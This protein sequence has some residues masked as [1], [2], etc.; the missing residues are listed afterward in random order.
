MPTLTSDVVSS[1]STPSQYF[2]IKRVGYENID[3]F[4]ES[5][6]SNYLKYKFLEKYTSIIEPYVD[7][8]LKM[9]DLYKSSKNTFQ[10]E[11]CPK[12]KN[13]GIIME[14]NCQVGS[15]AYNF[16]TSKPFSSHINFGC[17]PFDT[18]S[19]TVKE[20]SYLDGST[21]LSTFKGN[22]I[23]TYIRRELRAL[24]SA[25]LNT[26][27]QTMYKIWST[28]ETEGAALYG[29]KFHSITYLLRFHHF[30]AADRKT[31]HIHN[32]NGILMQHT[33][34]ENIFEA[35]LQ[36]IDPSIALP[37]WDF[38][39]D[40]A[41]GKLANESY[42][43]TP[44]IFGHMHKPR[45]FEGGFTYSQDSIADGVIP[46]GLWK[47]FKSD[48]NVFP[49][50]DYGYGYMRGP[51]NL[52]PNPYISRYTFNFSMYKMP[53]CNDHYA[54]MTDESMMSFFNFGEFAPHGNVH[55]LTGG[56]YGCD[57]FR[58]MLD[59][60]YILD[61]FSLQK[62][63]VSWSAVIMKTAYRFHMVTPEKNCKVN[64]DDVNLS[65]CKYQCEESS[66]EDLFKFISSLASSKDDPG[67][68]N[69]DLVKDGAKEAWMEFI[70]GGNGGKVH[71]QQ[72]T[73]HAVHTYIHAYTQ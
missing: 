73:I 25:D 36:A 32:G 13:G 66:K 28:S 54:L 43:L 41:E 62:M 72:F 50:M 35:S 56:A 20:I 67:F 37:Y 29:D 69:L 48:M 33:K 42:A 51:W 68:L 14:S 57:M 19:I 6:P 24:P 1:G 38:T 61:E 5:I 26:L 18:F 71:M 15:R 10:Y 39:I 34:F 11:V 17:S 23:C 47:N 2:M 30:N 3:Y 55:I 53:S 40:T 9:Y 64:T 22:L 8:E 59:K 16:T 65:E 31:D 60:G 4:D 27:V 12:S 70:C 21:V 49:D 44:S 63:C 45:N 7:M 52:N 58:P 46:D